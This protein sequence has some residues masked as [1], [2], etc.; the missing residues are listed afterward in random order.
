MSKCYQ[1][2]SMMT[3]RS[4]I[5]FGDKQHRFARRLVGEEQFASV[6]AIVAHG[7]R[8]VEQ[9]SREQEAIIASLVNITRQRASKSLA[10]FVA[11][12]SDTARGMPFV[13]LKRGGQP[14]DVSFRLLVH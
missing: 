1:E 2:D 13:V 14:I 4:S 12:K 11:P 3:K 8:F 10:E 5:S 7:L 9:E 6:S